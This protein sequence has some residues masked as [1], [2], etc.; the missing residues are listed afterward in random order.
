M[1]FTT[2]SE[3]LAALSGLRLSLTSFTNP[4]ILTSDG[5]IAET[6]KTWNICIVSSVF[7]KTYL[8]YGSGSP[9]RSWESF[10]D[11]FKNME[12]YQTTS[13][14][15]SQAP[16]WT[17]LRESRPYPLHQFTNTSPDP[18]IYVRHPPKET[19]AEIVELAGTKR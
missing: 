15:E 2:V 12:A 1:P 11:I 5:T 6:F 3:Q 4:V 13:P 9:P 16:S 18:A 17:Q 19:P 10:V 8:V 7:P 14:S